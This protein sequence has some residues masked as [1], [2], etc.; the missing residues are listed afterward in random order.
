MK[1]VAIGL[2]VG[3]MF[4]TVALA[5]EDVSGST[6]AAT[7]NAESDLGGCASNFSVTGSFFSGKQFKTSSVLPEV[8]SQIAFRRAR[9][10]ITKSDHDWTSEAYRIAVSDEKS[11]VITAIWGGVGN[12]K[13]TPLLTL[14]IESVSGAGTKIDFT[15][16]T[17]G[18]T[19]S[20]VDGVDNAF[21]K[22][23]SAVLSNAEPDQSAGKVLNSEYIKNGMPC[24]KEICLGDGLDELRKITWD[25]VVPASALDIKNGMA[26]LEENYRGNLIESA[27][28]LV[29]GT[30]SFDN[31]ALSKLGEVIA[32]CHE[33]STLTGTFTT[34]SGNPTDVEIDL[35]PSLDNS[36]QKWTVVSIRRHLPR[37]ES[38]KQYEEIRAQLDA[39]YG[40]FDYIKM[41]MQKKKDGDAQYIGDL[42]DGSGFGL[43]FKL[44]M[45]WPNVTKERYRFHPAC[46][47][48]KKIN[49][50]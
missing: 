7:S 44:E 48:I 32:A 34:Q 10:A 18:G 47:A 9:A 41:A 4:S 37:A 11:G 3:L 27:A 33:P 19:S 14:H 5:E 21:C 46:G 26:S 2:M 42:R 45:L 20:L 23:T 29:G 24:V 12:E 15:F 13:T 17:A 22:I 36:E 8:N 35:I 38:K 30:H 31:Q 16:S 49:I 50:D 1:K 40:A 39:R 6:R 28:Y 25:K 43:G